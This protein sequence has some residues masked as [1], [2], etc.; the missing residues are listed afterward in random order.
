[1]IIGKK[2]LIFEIVKLAVNHVKEIKSPHEM[3]FIYIKNNT[4]YSTDGKTMTKTFLCDLHHYIEGSNSEELKAYEV[5]K[6]LGTKI[7]LNPVELHSCSENLIINCDNI[8]SEYN[9]K[10]GYIQINENKEVKDDS[11]LYTEIVR[12]MN[13]K[14]TF[15]I[16]LFLKIYESIHLVDIFYLNDGM[17]PMYFES[18]FDNDKKVFIAVMPMAV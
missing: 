13:P 12:R 1:M 3:K 17:K 10:T 6:N 4:I 18:M 14:Y 5:V 2:S 8:H 7:E 16:D 9:N 15:N 11:T